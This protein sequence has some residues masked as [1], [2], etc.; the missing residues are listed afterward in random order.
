MGSASR[1][2]SL[3]DRGQHV[4]LPRN[5]YRCRFGD[6]I[7]TVEGATARVGLVVFEKLGLRRG[8]ERW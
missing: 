8:G 3:W 1:A 6:G 4:E 5:D 7:R 2:G